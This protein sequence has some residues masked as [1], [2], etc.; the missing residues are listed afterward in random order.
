MKCEANLCRVTL[1]LLLL[2]AFLSQPLRV[3]S[4]PSCQGPQETAIGPE[5]PLKLSFIDCDL[6][7]H[8]T[9]WQ[10]LSD[11]VRPLSLDNI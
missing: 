4:S 1:I 3:V 7:S 8:Q 6:I 9:M 10:Y 5:C 2:A 11:F